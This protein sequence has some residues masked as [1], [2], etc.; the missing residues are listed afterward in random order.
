MSL[1]KVNGGAIWRMSSNF[2][3]A[4]FALP[5]LVKITSHMTSYFLIV[6]VGVQDLDVLK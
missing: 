3:K 1:K 4:G 2:S 5:G 6:V